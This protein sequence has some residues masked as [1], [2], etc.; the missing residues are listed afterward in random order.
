M[1]MKKVSKNAVGAGCEELPHF[2]N[3][4]VQSSSSYL[5]FSAEGLGE[6]GGKTKWKNPTLEMQC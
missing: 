6:G 1:W 2:T 5:L 3:F 4:A